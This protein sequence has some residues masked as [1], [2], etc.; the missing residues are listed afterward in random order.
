MNNFCKNFVDS[1]CD[2]FEI[3][4]D[5]F[6]KKKKLVHMPLSKLLISYNFFKAITNFIW[7][8]WNKRQRFYPGYFFCTRN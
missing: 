7:D 4:V 1:L 2:K 6:Q 8:Y 5:S 3:E